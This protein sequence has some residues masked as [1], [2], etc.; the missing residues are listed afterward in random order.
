MTQPAKLPANE[1]LRLARLKR[2]MVLDT[3]PE[4]IFDEVTKIASAVCGTPIALISLIDEQRQWFKANVGVEGTSETSRD[5]AFCAH[6]ILQNAVMEVP[7]AEEDTRFKHNPLVTSEPNIRF[8]AGAPLI[9]P[10]GLNIGT[11]C[12]IDR[13]PRSLNAF[14]KIML[15]HLS[16]LVVKALLSREQ[17]LNELNEQSRHYTNII[18]CSSDAIWSKTL[19]GIFLTWNIGAEKIFGY[20]FAEMV[21]QRV[22][23]LYPVDRQDEERLLIEQ[24]K[25]QQGVDRYETERITKS[26]ARIQVSLTLSPI[27]D[28]QGELIGISTIAR[29][30]T[31]Q[32]K[33]EQAFM[34]E[35]ERLKVTMDSIGD[36]VITTNT[37]GMVEY[38]NP[39]AERMT[40]WCTAEARGLPLEKVFN[41]VHETSRQPAL[42]PITFCLQE[43]KVVGLPSQTMLISRHGAEF[44]IE[45]SASP[46]HSPAGDILGAVLVFHDVTLQRKMA[47]EMTYRATHDGLTG[48]INR[49]EFEYRLNALLQHFQ[50]TQRHAVLFIDLDQFK[51]VNDTCGHATGDRLLKDVAQLMQK[52]I[53]ATD[54]FARVGG[55]EFAMILEEC[56][57]D[58]AMKIAQ[59]ICAAMNDYRFMHEQKLFR[60]GA[61]IGLVM[62]DKP[63]PNLQALMQAADNACYAA[64]EAGRNR[65]YLHYDLAATTGARCSDAEWASRIEFAIEKNEFSLFCQR[66]L[67]LHANE[68]VHCEVLIRWNDGQGNLIEPNVFLPAAERFYMAPRIDYWVV[69][70]VFSWL[71]QHQS[72]IDYIDSVAINLSGQS[73]GREDFLQDI[74]ALIANTAIDYSKVCFE[75]TETAAITNLSAAA[76]FI[77]AMR[78]H[79]IRFSLD[80]FGSGVSSF[81]YLKSLDVD[82]LKIDGQ[83]IQDIQDDPVDLA[84][85]RC[86]I[87]VAKVTGKKTIA[88]CVETAES[89]HIIRLLGA[90]YI[91]GYLYHRP[92]PINQLLVKELEQTVTPL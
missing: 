91:Q 42:N 56:A 54:T 17:L 74:L 89:R 9:M 87:E 57:V 26:G 33:I 45:D 76:Q 82:Y 27:L 72:Q 10:E 58:A 52:C 1:A 77:Q 20:S 25:Q 70:S 3:S 49:L 36:A 71:S 68:G 5:I 51:I 92:Q 44:G 84:T 16:Q 65:V 15:E 2:L 66:I 90:D 79:Q 35:H 14:Q 88:E 34:I 39:V 19:D 41:I 80:D 55:D 63:W 78:K 23:T 50:A 61:S 81:A 48:L 37:Q 13:E 85:V 28:L 83:F 31:Q 11:L 64:K 24:I 47:Q 69:K 60:V 40:G 59:N 30:I 67:P 46:I 73:V 86:I 75:V 7:N 43:N 12:V 53:R 38:L 8:Y 6:T 22:D 21:G 4:T 29:D 32:K 18:E 62:L